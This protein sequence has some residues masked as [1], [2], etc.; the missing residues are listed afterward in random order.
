MI[1]VIV[2][3][4]SPYQT[5]MLNRLVEK[6]DDDVL[7]FYLYGV[8]TERGWGDVGITHRHVVLNR[9][10]GW[11]AL[12]KTL[13]SPR[14]CAV[15]L[16]GYLGTAR[17][18]AAN[19]ARI[20]RRPLVMRGAVNAR[21]ELSRPTLRRLAKRW[22]LRVMLGRPEIWTIGSAS[23]SYWELL[24]QRRHHLVP[25][26]LQHLPGDEP[27]AAALRARLGV[28]ER[29]TFAFVGRLEPIKGLSDLLVAYDIVRQQVPPDSTALIIVGPGTLEQD[30]RRYVST[31]PD[32]HYLGPIP[33]DKLGA[34][35]AAADLFVAPSLREP[36]GWVI[37]EALGFGTRVIASEAVAAADDLCNEQT[38][39]RCPVADPPALAAAM[40]AEYWEGRRRA[41]KLECVDTAQRMADRL[42]HLIGKVPSSRL[43][44]DDR[45]TD[46]GAGPDTSPVP[47]RV[48]HLRP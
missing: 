38:G 25:N 48:G 41:P 44:E 45:V 42:E 37:N 13:L 5:P 39:R 34:I 28:G 24:G 18:L 31:R 30:V 16:F 32:C 46:A 20:R 26:M 23:A 12:I 6:L 11:R 22:Y 36:W 1:L 9:S 40:L 29:F 14:L 43:E 4:P 27:G 35:Y 7:V 15:L 19:V 10:G 33:Y 2:E 47:D 3:C 21:D 17:L 8:D